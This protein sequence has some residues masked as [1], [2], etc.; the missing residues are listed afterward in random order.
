MPVIMMMMTIH[1]CS[2][3]SEQGHA[4][5]DDDDDDDD[6]ESSSEL[7]TPVSGLD[8][9][10]RWSSQD[11]SRNLRCYATSF[12]DF[13]CDV[14]PKCYQKFKATELHAK[15]CHFSHLN[16]CVTI[17]SSPG[18]NEVSQTTTSG[19][20]VLQTIKIWRPSKYKL[21]QSVGM[22]IHNKCMGERC[23]AIYRLFLQWHGWQSRHVPQVWGRWCL[24]ITP[25]LVLICYLLS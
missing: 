10:W 24:P 6:D 5:D 16:A 4:R 18:C 23:C 25:E 20:G 3:K 8:C 21:S 13:F 9:C 19:C 1:L 11:V 22:Y 12:Q 17:C 7:E 14:T 2:C 15:E